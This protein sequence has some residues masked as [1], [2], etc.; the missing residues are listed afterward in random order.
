MLAY[1]IFVPGFY[2]GINVV[3]N[4]KAGDKL[5]SPA[6][7]TNYNKQKLKKILGLVLEEIDDLLQVLGLIGKILGSLSK[8]LGRIRIDT[9]HTI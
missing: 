1:C 8:H 9:H 5:T 6:F 4:Q 3:K 7:S 2:V